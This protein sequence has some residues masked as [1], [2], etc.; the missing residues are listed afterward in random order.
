MSLIQRLR[1]AIFQTSE[2]VQIP[3]PYSTT[4][5]G[6]IMKVSVS[7]LSE[8]SGL[9]RRVVTKRLDGLSSEPGPNNA[10]LFDSAEAIRA[11]YAE[12]AGLDPQ[13]ERAL[14]DRERRKALELS[15]A[16]AERILVPLDEVSAAWSD[17][18]MIAKN[19][20]L[21]LPARVASDVLRLKSQREIESVIK[22]AVLE[23][24]T[25]LSADPVAA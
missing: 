18:V 19:R 17:Q 7:K 4:T 11:L 24:L 13:Q 3:P 22:A 2:L 25:E 23:I 1:W 9:D 16:K 14:L 20:L 15:N 10:K 12:I 21:S 8:I 6:Q 5:T